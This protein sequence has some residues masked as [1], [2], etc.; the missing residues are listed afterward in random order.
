MRRSKHN[1]HW[2]QLMS[3]ADDDYSIPLRTH[4]HNILLRTPE[5][6][7]HTQEPLLQTTILRLPPKHQKTLTPLQSHRSMVHWTGSHSSSLIPYSCPLP[8][9]EN[10]EPWILRT[11]R[12]CKVINGDSTSWRSPCRIRNIH[13]VISRLG[14][15]KS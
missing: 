14:I 7:M 4:T 10:C 2:E 8:S 6:L 15:W 12:I 1:A 5:A 13:T 3:C 11:K 9:T